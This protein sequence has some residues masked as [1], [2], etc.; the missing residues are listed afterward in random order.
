MPARRR[1]RRHAR[2]RR[3]ARRQG[4]DD[5]PAVPAELVI[6]HS[7]QVDHFGT[8]RRPRQEH[9]PSSSSATSERYAFLRWGQNAFQNFQVVPPNTGIVHQVNLEYL[10]ASSSTKQGQGRRVPRHARRHRLAHDDDQRPRRAGLGRRR[11]RGRG[12]DARP[13]DL[14]AAS[15]RSSASSSPASSPRRDRDGPRADRDRDA[16]QER[17]RRQVRR[18]LR[19]RLGTCRWPTAR[20]SPTWRPSSAH[21]RHLPDRRRDA[22]LSRAHRPRRRADRARRGVREGTGHVAQTRQRGA[23]TPTC[24]SSTSR[25]S[26]PLAGPKR[27]QD[28]VALDTQC[29][30]STSSRIAEDRGQRRDRRPRR[31]G[32]A[33][34]RAHGRR[35]A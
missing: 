4:A 25:R 17:R 11:H 19:R 5:Q 33:N 35:R 15:R 26:S 10:A 20:R 34:V 12:R 22:A 16:A 7:V 2:R 8:A 31:D 6:D 30:C 1:S 24:S 21:L 28:R 32:R 14:D 3:Q 13:A 18:V 23:T 27:P 9:R 29:R